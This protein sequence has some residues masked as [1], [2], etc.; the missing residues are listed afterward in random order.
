MSGHPKGKT[1]KSILQGVS[2][3]THSAVR[4]QKAIT[5]YVDPFEIA[6]DPHDADIICCTHDH[7]DHFSPKD[8]RKVKNDSTVLILT[9]SCSDELLDEFDDSHIIRVL[10]NQSFTCKG[11]HIETVRAYNVHNSFHPYANNYV[12]YVLETDG[13]RYYIVGD[14]DANE[15]VLKTRCD[16]IFIP[17]GG[18]YTMDAKEAA[19]AVNQMDIAAAIPTHYGSI[20]GDKSD[21]ETF[22]SL[23]DDPKKGV[24]MLKF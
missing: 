24:I 20:T 5:V 21:G 6:D 4:I 13:C 22:K 11:I 16:V 18:K 10:P 23:L 17:V 3:I 12:G 9:P 15:D 19:K 14:S 2:V 7:Y 1:M 8:I